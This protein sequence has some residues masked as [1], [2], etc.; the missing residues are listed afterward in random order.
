MNEESV[1]ELEYTEKF[2]SDIEKLRSTPNLI[3]KID[4]FLDEIEQHPSWGTGKPE[5]LKGYG[6]RNV[7]SR[8]IDPK[9]RLV[10]EVFEEEGLVKILSAYGHYDDK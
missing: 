1:Y 8:R 5:A 3:K 7:Y 10:Y 4:A 9:H 2:Y 6:E